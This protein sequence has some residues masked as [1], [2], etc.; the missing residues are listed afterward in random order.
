MESKQPE[1]KFSSGAI[2]ATIWKNEGI[3]KNQEKTNFYTISLDRRFQDKEKNWKSTNSFRINDL[4]KA[5]LLMNKA[6]E[7]LVL[8]EE[9]SKSYDN[10]LIDI[11]NI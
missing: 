3:G 9:D 11:E 6:Y 1:K 4:P 7:Y 10:D 5:A 8:K 2:S